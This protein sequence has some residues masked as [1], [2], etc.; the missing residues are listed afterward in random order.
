M[1]ERSIWR[2]EEEEVPDEMLSGSVDH[3]FKV[4]HVSDYGASEWLP[5]EGFEHLWESDGR[6]IGRWKQIDPNIKPGWTKRKQR[7]GEAIRGWRTILVRGVQMRLWTPWQ[8]E[9]EFSVAQ[10]PEWHRYM[11]KGAVAPTS[12][13]SAKVM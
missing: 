5:I 9:T 6:G 3:S 2:I 1:P 7:W 10:S 8:V 4:P 12:S 11:G 13:N